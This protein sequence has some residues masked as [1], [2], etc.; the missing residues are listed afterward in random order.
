M[1]THYVIHLFLGS[2]T[3]TMLC[4]SA[5][6]VGHGDT[7]KATPFSVIDEA[8]TRGQIDFETA[9]VNKVLAIFHPEKV[10]KRFQLES[11]QPE[12]CATPLFLEIRTNWPRLS[13]RTRD[14]LEPYL[15]RPTES[16]EQDQYGHP[17]ETEAENYD[18]PGGH[19]KIWYV[20]TTEDAPDTTDDDPEDGVPDWVNRC[21]EIFDYVW[22]QEVDEMG[23][24][25]PPSD[26]A[27]YPGEE[28]YG[29][30]SKY[31]VYIEAL[32]GNIFGYTQSEYP[33]SK[34]RYT[35]YIVVD[36]DYDWYP[37]YNRGKLPVNA[38]E[39][40]AA[41]EFFHSIHFG[42]DAAEL[43]D[44]WWMEVSAVW[45]EDMM[46]DDVD[47]Y[48]AY[49]RWFFNDPEISLNE[50][51]G[52][53]EYASCVWAM[54]LDQ[55]YGRDIVRDI[56][57]GCALYSALEAMERALTDRGT[58]LAEAFQTFTVWNYFTGSR[59]NPDLYYEEGADY[60]MV[61][62]EDRHISYPASGTGHVDHLGCNYIGFIPQG[63]TGGL[64]TSFDGGSGPTWGAMIIEYQSPSIHSVT[65]I[66]LDHQSDGSHA[67]RNWSIY[68]EIVLIPN[69]VST[70]GQNFTYTYEGEYDPILGA[71]LVLS[72]A[73]HDFGNIM[74]GNVAEWSLV[75]YNVGLDSR[76]IDSI[77]VT[78]N[79]FEM[80]DMTF[81]QTMEAAESI[82][83]FVLFR[84]T[85]VDE[86]SGQMT[87]ASDD[88]LAP[89]IT[90]QLSGSGITPS[91][92][93]Q[94]YPNPFKIGEHEETYFPFD[95]SEDVPDASF[96]IRT[97]NGELVREMPLGFL[98]KGQYRQS[99]P[100]SWDG[101]NENGK[102]VASGI[103]LYTLKAG[104]FVETK[105]I[106]LV[107]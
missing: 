28:D 92:L 98:E 79:I 71:S 78:P 95:L 76:T 73:D 69:I 2:L 25:P 3:M 60:P 5:I 99:T 107:R 101:K 64:R 22:A 86:Y 21:G 40:T 30:D 10:D 66:A 32:G 75:I 43:S 89:I 83:V 90:I 88:S 29:G 1:K 11:L 74:V 38:L 14:I 8:Y 91:L 82:A 33:V 27:W 55:K 100:L 106:A 105:K 57:E 94:N 70:T 41:H 4:F 20:T 68:R 9:L 6:C 77:S 51:L 44:R 80:S 59:A 53:H 49:L 56:W 31:D 93:L 17:Y 47:D 63:K 102:W 34:R 87:L 62:F 12:K 84:P 85:E 24:D 13:P 65:D 104:S 36:D 103:Y 96:T 35:S 72:E 18:S 48:F 61:S 42:Y 23:Y 97:L 15:L 50:P 45:M 54:F 16:D 39:V 7:G 67:T 58:S 52:I 46:Y 26:G 81:P 37:N 19:F